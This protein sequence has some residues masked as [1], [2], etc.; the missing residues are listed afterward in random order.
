MSNVTIPNLPSVGSLSGS[1][2]LQVVQS[3]TSYRVTA[4]QIANL[5]ANGG[6]VTS[7]TAQSPLSGGTITTTGTIGLNNN[8][9]TND[10]L[11]QMA[12]YTIKGN[13]T[14]GSAQPQDLTAA[15]VRTLLGAGTITSLTA[16]TG[17]TTLS[18]NP[19]TTSGTILIDVTGV[20]SGTYG[21]ATAVPQ[22]YN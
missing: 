7:I 1:S 18:T 20:T 13:N 3:G 8:G 21:T 4:Q 12:G 17:L 10:Y 16:G 9:V 14:S 11:A 2:Q 15:Q 5:N 6:T 22:N 19:L